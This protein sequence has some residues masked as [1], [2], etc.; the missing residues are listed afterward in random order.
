MRAT[1]GILTVLEEGFTV[2]KCSFSIQGLPG[3]PGI[4]AP[5]QW[6]AGH[7]EHGLQH[8]ELCRILLALTPSS[9]PR[10]ALAS[11]FGMPKS[12]LP[13]SFILSA[14]GCRGA[15]ALL[16]SPRTETALPACFFQGSLPREGKAAISGPGVWLGGCNI[17]VIS[18]F[19]PNQ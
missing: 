12:H 13:T 6:R 1:G 8:R 2:W 15:L 3:F 7:L 14:L 10:S 18:S 9:Y 5:S 11:S 4:R 17:P 19:L 16:A